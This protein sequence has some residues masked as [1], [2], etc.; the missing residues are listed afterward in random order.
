ML[1][2]FWIK[3]RKQKNVKKGEKKK[4]KEK[5]SIFRLLSHWKKTQICHNIPDRDLRMLKHPSTTE[6]VQTTSPSSNTLAAAL[7]GRSLSLLPA[8]LVVVVVLWAAAGGRPLG[9]AVLLGLLQELVQTEGILLKLDW[10][11]PP[12]P[13]VG[14][15]ELFVWNKPDGGRERKTD[16]YSGQQIPSFSHWSLNCVRWQY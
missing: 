14:T 3:L 4:E 8:L 1:N 10:P 9:A 6:R 15:W 12:L 5:K 13:V 7:R 16:Y 11:F 2:I